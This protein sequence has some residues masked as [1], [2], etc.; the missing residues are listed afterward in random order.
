MKSS[1][2]AYSYIDLREKIAKP[3]A[4]DELDKRSREKLEVSMKTLGE[5]AYLYSVIFNLFKA[6]IITN[7]VIL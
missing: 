4:E 2:I 7:A 5:N 1:P 3:P 6:E